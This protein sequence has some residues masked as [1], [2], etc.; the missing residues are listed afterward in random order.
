MSSSSDV[1][2]LN[3]C[4]GVFTGFVHGSNP[5]KLDKEGRVEIVAP[6]PSLP[7]LA[8]KSIP[9][10]DE[11]ALGCWWQAVCSLGDAGPSFASCSLVFSCMKWQYWDLWTS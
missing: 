3:S 7:E 1:K 5:R 4:V 11:M 2:Y 6:N 10:A 8:S 9:A